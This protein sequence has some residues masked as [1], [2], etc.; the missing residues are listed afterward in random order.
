[1]VDYWETVNTAQPSPLHISTG[2]VPV[3]IPLNSG[4]VLGVVIVIV[5]IYIFMIIKKN[6][7]KRT[8]L[9]EVF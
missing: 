2:V 6:R 7:N 1:M 9:Y 3:S 5:S 4:C 8:N